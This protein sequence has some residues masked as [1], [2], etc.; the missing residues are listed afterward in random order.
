MVEEAGIRL[1]V[2]RDRVTGLYACP[3]CGK[4]EDATYFFTVKDLIKHILVHA[5]VTKAERVKVAVEQF[6]EEGEAAKIE[7]EEE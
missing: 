2:R 5:G 6:A 3:V 4:N 7:E 1:K